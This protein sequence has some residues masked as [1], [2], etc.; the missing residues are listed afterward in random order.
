MNRRSSIKR[1]LGLSLI[2]FAPTARSRTAPA[3]SLVIQRAQLA[4]FQYHQGAMVW[5]QLQTGEPIRLKRE[6]DNPYDPNAIALYWR[7]HK[8]GYIP[9]R[10]NKTLAGMLDQGLP[11]G[12]V[13][14]ELRDSWDPWQRVEVEI[15]L[16]IPT[17]M[18]RDGHPGK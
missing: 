16:T 2:G 3:R 13:I 14:A 6:A 4:G 11:L 10:E 7:N 18:G 9:R 12:A 17:I 8:L 1:L 15:M 5:H